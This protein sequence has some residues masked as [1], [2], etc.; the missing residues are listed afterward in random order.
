MGAL[1]EVVDVGRM[2]D[3]ETALELAGFV[4]VDT[5]T[6]AETETGFVDVVGRALDESGFVL[7]ELATAEDEIGL[8]DVAVAEMTVDDDSGFVLVAVL[9]TFSETDALAETLASVEDAVV[10]ESVDD[11][12]VLEATEELA[13]EDMT[14]LEAKVEE[15]EVGSTV[16]VALTVAEA[17]AETV[18]LTAREEDTGIVEFA[19]AALVEV[20]LAGGVRDP[21]TT[22]SASPE[23]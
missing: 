21:K 13:D 15:V 3:E 9:D 11:V 23:L 6:E 14:E 18:A 10:L 4:L 7:D 20:T 2:V 1:E 12:V 17:V 5:P 22:I 19:A 8:V 16:E